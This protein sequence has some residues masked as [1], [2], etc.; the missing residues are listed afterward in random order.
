MKQ[1]LFLVQFHIILLEVEV[2]KQIRK[3][4]FVIE[5][6][7]I[8]F[9]FNYHSISVLTIVNWSYL[10]ST[11]LFDYVAHYYSFINFVSLFVSF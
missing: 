5:R 7:L 4:T 1:A 6:K 10:V 3:I 11:M 8:I 9:I 2:A